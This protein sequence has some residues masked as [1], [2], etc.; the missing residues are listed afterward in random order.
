MTVVLGVNATVT[1]RNDDNATAIHTASSMTGD[2]SSWDSGCIG[3]VAA[4]CSTGQ[5]SYTYTFTIAGTYYYR[6]DYHPW[7]EGEIIVLAP[8]S[9]TTTASATT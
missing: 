6:C 9:P 5:S 4:G 1:W 8:S 7:M 3:T 2:P